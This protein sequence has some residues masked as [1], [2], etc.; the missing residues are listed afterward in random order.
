MID[1]ADRPDCLTQAANWRRRA[2]ATERPELRAAFE[3]IAES[4]E[5]LS[6]QAF[7]CRRLVTTIASQRGEVPRCC[8]DAAPPA[9]PGLA[10]MVVAPE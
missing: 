6:R 7:L 10:E 8:C 5:M 1:E 9:A 4:Y 3:R 2:L